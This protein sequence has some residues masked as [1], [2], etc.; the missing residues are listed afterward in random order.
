MRRPTFKANP[1]PRACSV[2]IYA[3]KVKEEELKRGKRIRK[4]AEIAFAKARMPPTMQKWADR[5]KSEPP[6][7]LP[8]EYPF[9]PTIGRQVTGKM[10][11]SAAAKFHAELAKK[12][13]QKTQTKPRSPDFVQRPKKVLDKDFV[14]EGTRKPVDKQALLMQ[15]LA[16]RAKQTRAGD[17]ESSMKNMNPASTKAT[18]LSQARR[19]VEIQKR[20]EG[21]EKTAKEDRDRRPTKAAK[22]KVAKAMRDQEAI[23]GRKSKDAELTV[24]LATA[25]K[26]MRENERKWKAQKDAMAQ[27]LASQPMLCEQGAGHQKNASNLALLKA[28]QKIMAMFEEEGV[29]PKNFLSEQSKQVLEDEAL[30]GQLKKAYMK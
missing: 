21:L 19:R 29:D 10:L 28:T 2:L 5:K 14:N 23:A 17:G 4:N 27:R 18:A 9:R 20:H 6:K 11:A 12:K 25:K 30:K 22:D 16:A 3:E 1:I 7:L 24:K 26:H 8:E 13:G 15:Q